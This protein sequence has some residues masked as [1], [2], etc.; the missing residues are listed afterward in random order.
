MPDFFWISEISEDQLI[1]INKQ[2]GDLKS[3]GKCILNAIGHMHNYIYI[4]LDLVPTLTLV[5]NQIVSKL[6]SA[7]TE[8]TNCVIVTIFLQTI[9]GFHP[10][11]YIIGENFI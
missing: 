4:K 1:N 2:D 11:F 9:N 10:V 8:Y 3:Y 7:F 5:S 6:E